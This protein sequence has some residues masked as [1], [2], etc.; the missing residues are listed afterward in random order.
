[1]TF[2]KRLFCLFYLLPAIGLAQDVTGFTQFFINPYLLNPS[3][4]GIDGRKAAYLAYRKQWASIEGGPSIGSFSIHG[5]LTAGLNGGLNIANDTR[6]ILNSTSFQ[7]TVGYTVSI[8]NHKFIRFG[9]S[10]GAS[11]TGADVEAIENINDPAL[12]ELASKHM[13]LI[14]NAGLSIHLK[15]FHLGASMPNIFSPSYISTQSFEVAEVKPF[16]SLIIHASN[17]F[18]F[19]KDKHVF[20]PYVIYRMS[21]DL[22]GQYEV[23]GVLHLNHVLWLGGSMKQDF[24][25]SALAGIKASHF[26]AIGGSYSLSNSGANELNSP[27]YEINLSY[28]FGPRKKNTPQYSFV[29]TVKEKEKKKTGKSASEQIAERRKQ[30]ELAKKKQQEELAKK[31]QEEEKTLALAKKQQEEAATRKLQE[32]QALAKKQQEELIKKQQAEALA[33]NQTKPVVTPP[34]ETKP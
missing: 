29:N 9:L 25:L 8:D 34:V 28:L 14:G 7:L 31:K 15:S 24:G 23:A 17:R 32:E 33:K 4:A 22:P 10:A 2:Q 12:A 11:S 5:P 27:T 20:E 3:Y 18:Y 19:A 21:A 6:G 16:Q 1:M 13:T 26:F 30:E